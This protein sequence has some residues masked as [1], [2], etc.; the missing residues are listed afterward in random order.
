MNWIKNN[1]YVT[2][3]LEE[4]GEGIFCGEESV[5]RLTTPRV[6]TLYHKQVVEDVKEAVESQEDI[7]DVKE[8]TVEKPDGTEYT[9][10]FE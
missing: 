8:I 4:D 9:E 7:G 6:V 2:V 1:I 3:D 10:V 5:I